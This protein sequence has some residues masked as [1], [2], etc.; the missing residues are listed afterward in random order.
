MFALD[1]LSISPLLGGTHEN[2]ETVNS[3]K[4][5]KSAKKDNKQVV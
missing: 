3:P 2:Y 5:L 1:A 4:T